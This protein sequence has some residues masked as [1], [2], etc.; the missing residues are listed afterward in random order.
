M[1]ISQWKGF[2]SCEAKELAKLNGTY[3][4]PDKKAFHLG[5]Y[6]HKWAEGKL[7]QYIDANEHLILKKTGKQPEKLKDYIKADQ[8]IYA[9]ES[10]KIA[11]QALQGEHEVIMVGDIEGVKW[12]CMIDIL[13]P[14][15]R[16]VD[17]KYVANFKPIY[18]REEKRYLSFIEHWGYHYQMAGYQEFIRQNTGEVLPPNILAVTKEEPPDKGIF[19]GFTEFEMYNALNYIKLTQP[20]IQAV[21]NGLVEPSRC[22]KCAYCVS[23]KKITEVIKWNDV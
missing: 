12:K 15:I 7:K 19:S 9:L 16:F 23:T 4:E 6:L 2:L 14:G 13:L 3:E 17:L 5:H 8:A 10:D 11:T 21:K 20:R 22:G 1:S 18:S